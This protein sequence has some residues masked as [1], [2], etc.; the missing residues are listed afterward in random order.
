M[1]AAIDM[2]TDNQSERS[3]AITSLRAN[4]LLRELANADRAP[5]VSSQ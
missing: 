5:E 4:A 1:R 3:S 2:S